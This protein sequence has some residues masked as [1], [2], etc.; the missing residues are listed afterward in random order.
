MSSAAPLISRDL[1]SFVHRD[2]HGAASLQLAVEGMRCAGCMASVEK[3][4]MKVRGVVAAR[5]NLSSQRLSVTWQEAATSP[6]AI[7]AAVEALGFK[8]YPFVAKQAE[9]KEANE[10]KRLLRYLGVAPLRP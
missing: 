7:I 3:N 1:S 5:V 9:T 2:S 4:V 6:D 10:E 8:A